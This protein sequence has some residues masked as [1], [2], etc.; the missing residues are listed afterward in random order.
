MSNLTRRLVSIGVVAVAVGISP[1]AYADVGTHVTKVAMSKEWHYGYP[2]EAMQ[3]RFDIGVEADASVTGIA[4]QTPVGGSVSLVLDPDDGGWSYGAKYSTPSGLDAFGHGDYTF[5]IT[6]AADPADTTVV[7]YGVPGGGPIPQVT[8]EPIVS[9]PVH[10]DVAVPTSL[11]LEWQACTD[12][13]AQTIGIEWD[14]Q[15]GIGLSG[16]VEELALSETQYG[17]IA[18]SPN[19]DYDFQF[20]FDHVYRGT[21]ADGISYVIDTDAELDLLFHTVPEPATLSLLA[22][23]GLMLLRRRRHDRE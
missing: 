1:S 20:T 9:S 6:Y 13:S 14:P 19:T 11:L 5:T 3:Y 4:C 15:N 8:Q 16:E 22:L 12:P 18:L 10:M 7:H 23:G 17:P 2:G 21:N